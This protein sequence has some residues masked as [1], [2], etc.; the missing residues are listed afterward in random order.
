MTSKN[1]HSS[2]R[3]QEMSSTTLNEAENK[4]AGFR[5]AGIGASAGGVEAIKLFLQ[6]LS[7]QT[8][9]AFVIVQHLSADY[10]SNLSHL[11]SKETQMKVN[12]V[13]DG[14]K[15]RPNEIYVIPPDTYMS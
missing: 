1:D 13:N 12:L 4:S 2:A 9:I 7:G 11:L 5:V 10:E 14:M 15:I 3:K 8:G 6:H